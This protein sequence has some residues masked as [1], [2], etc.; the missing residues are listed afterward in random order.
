[1]K[2]AQYEPYSEGR[3]NG[4]SDSAK[5]AAQ[6]NSDPDAVSLRRRNAA[7]GEELG[8]KTGAALFGRSFERRA[9]MR[10]NIGPNVGP[11]IGTS[12]APTDGDHRAP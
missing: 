8:Q 10:L 11:N 6:P 2:L 3:I 12:A 9:T 4:L 7:G 5:F 1:M